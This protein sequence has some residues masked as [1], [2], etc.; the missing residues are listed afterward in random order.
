MRA[1]ALSG[2]THE[3]D[4]D[5]LRPDHQYFPLKSYYVLV[6]DATGEHRTIAAKEYERPNR[7]EPPEWPVLYGGAEGR[8]AY[9]QKDTPLPPCPPI[10]MLAPPCRPLL[11]SAAPVGVG[12]NSLRRS[13]SMNALAK[14]QNGL[15]GN[16]PAFWGGAGQPFDAAKANEGQGFLAAS[17]NSQTITSNIASVTSGA[18]GAGGGSA[19]IKNDPRLALLDRRQ[20]MVSGRVGLGIADTFDKPADHVQALVAKARRMHTGLNKKN[21]EPPIEAEKPGYCENC[22]LRYDDFKVVSPLFP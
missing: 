21:P 17:G 9:T 14:K 12:V 16:G 6:E 1:E 10:A 5:V 19:G 15:V 13:I 18:V 11:A 4:P 2:I 3:R 22:R 7:S 8:S 20:V